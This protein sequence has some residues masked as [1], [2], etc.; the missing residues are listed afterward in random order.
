MVQ[1]PTKPSIG[2]AE[3]GGVGSVPA[4]KQAPAPET[5]T[6][7]SATDRSNNNCGSQQKLTRSLLAIYLDAPDTVVDKPGQMD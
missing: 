5:R 4:N 3:G 1:T 7:A 6:T 2:K